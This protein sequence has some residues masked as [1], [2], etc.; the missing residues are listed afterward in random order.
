MCAKVLTKAEARETEQKIEPLGALFFDYH[1][2]ESIRP[3][4]YR[5]EEHRKRCQYILFI[6][7]LAVIRKKIVQG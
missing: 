6:S 4:N 7:L 3:I 2:E 1:Q 5:E